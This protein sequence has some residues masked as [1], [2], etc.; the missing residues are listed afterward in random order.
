MIE[1]YLAVLLFGLGSIYNKSN[2]SNENNT[3]NVNETNVY[4][5]N[6]TKLILLWCESCRFC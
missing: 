3:S 6:N 4:K 2:T 1:I 5:Q